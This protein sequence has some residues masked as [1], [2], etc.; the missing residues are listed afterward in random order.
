MVEQHKSTSAISYLQNIHER[1]MN[2]CEKCLFHNH[3]MHVPALS[4]KFAAV[5]TTCLHR[6]ILQNDVCMYL[7]YVLL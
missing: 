5:Y 3:D 6:I 4:S 7:V 1:I 2:D